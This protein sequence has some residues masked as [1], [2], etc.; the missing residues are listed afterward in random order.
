MRDGRAV[1]RVRRW[2]RSATVSL[3]TCA[4][5]LGVAVPTAH[6]QSEIDVEPPLIEHDAIEL[7]EPGVAQEFTASVVDD[8]EL[9]EVLLFHRFAGEESFDETPMRRVATSSTYTATVSTEGGDT[10]SIEYY[11]QARDEAGNRVI[12]GYAFSPLVR[13]MDGG[14][15]AAV[16]GSDPVPE[17]RSGSGRRWLYVGL[18][19]LAVGGDRRGGRRER[20]RRFPTDR[21]GRRGRLHRRHRSSLSGGRG[22][23]TGERRRGRR[24][25]RRR[26]CR[27][28]G[29]WRRAG[30]RACARAA[31]RRR[32]RMP[33]RAAPA[34]PRDPG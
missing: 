5:L 27:T 31:R 4:A 22:A 17:A 32:C 10:R 23:A 3:A 13:R 33:R 29:P 7:G 9:A 18:G 6:A 28:V 34:A 8:R 1:E 12:K 26:R 16:A 21:R 14:A 24:V 25:T 30:D 15:G 20:R 19:V 2:V 11:I